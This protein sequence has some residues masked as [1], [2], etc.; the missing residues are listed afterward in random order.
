MKAGLRLRL[1]LGLI[2]IMIEVGM[3]I[4]IEIRVIT[5][6]RTKGRVDD[7]DLCNDKE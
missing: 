5:T 4:K 7:W 6:A 3:G 1:R 2:G